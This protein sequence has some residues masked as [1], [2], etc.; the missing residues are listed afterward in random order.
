[1][2]FPAAVYTSVRKPGT[3]NVRQ[4]NCN[5]D[6]SGHIAMSLKDHGDVARLALS[7]A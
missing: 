2:S 4:I 3:R 6:M 7:V 1:M 5:A